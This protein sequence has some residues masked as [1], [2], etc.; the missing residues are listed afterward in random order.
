MVVLVGAKWCPACVEMKNSVLPQVEKR[1]AF[2]RVTLAL[3]D[4]DEEKELG[5]QLLH[6]NT[7]PQLLMFRRSGT[8]WKVRRLIGGQDV[9]SV[10]EF[11]HEGLE[12]AR[13]D[14][15]DSERASVATKLARP[16]AE[17]GR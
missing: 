1:G 12:L 4:Y 9:E 17:L 15:D 14:H 11:V 6:G 16:L 2:K 3:V 5:K 13:K 8:K 10:E 7:I